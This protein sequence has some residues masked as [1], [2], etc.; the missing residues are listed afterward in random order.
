[1]CAQA[2]EELHKQKDQELALKDAQVIGQQ[3][4]ASGG[5]VRLTGVMDRHAAREFSACILQG[6]LL[7]YLT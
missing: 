2:N 5:W 3:R 1:M 6:P 4:G 7:S